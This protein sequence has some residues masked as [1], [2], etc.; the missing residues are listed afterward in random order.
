M[1]IVWY[2]WLDR[3]VFWGMCIEM[4]NEML[5][6]RILDMRKHAQVFFTKLVC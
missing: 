2:G 4:L 6:G 5:L 3:S 1:G